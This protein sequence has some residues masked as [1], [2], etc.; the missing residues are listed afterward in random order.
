MSQSRVDILNPLLLELKLRICV[1]LAYSRL[2]SISGTGCAILASVTSRTP[3]SL[4]FY[5]N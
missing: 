4:R 5:F 2:G 3:S 1:Y